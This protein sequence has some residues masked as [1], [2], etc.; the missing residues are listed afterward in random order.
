MS[1]SQ[2]LAVIF[3]LNFGLVIALVTIGVSAHSLAVLAEG[4]DY[5]LDAAGAALALLAIRLSARTPG[6]PGRPAV[7]DLAALVNCGWLF[8]LEVFVAA[9]AADR[10][11][12]RTPAVH[13]LP[14]LVVSGVAA[15][16]MTVGVLVLRADD[17]DA[18]DADD[19]DAGDVASEGRD[20]SVA[21]VMLDTVADAAAAAGV[22]ATGG[23][24]LATGGWYWLDPA[25]ALVIAVVIGYHALALLRKVI[26]RLRPP[27]PH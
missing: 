16:A 27:A 6:R 20:L 18:D 21:A 5:L 8:L 17:G 10:L 3:A 4:G 26:G 2:R 7:T 23:I 24:I 1:R 11:I 14:V 12:T 19:D 15:L 22:A 9:A 25:V 13:G